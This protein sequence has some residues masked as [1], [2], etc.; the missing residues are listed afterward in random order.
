M[1]QAER[2]AK[3]RYLLDEGRWPTRPFLLDTLRVSPATLKR[4]RMNEPVVFDRERRGWRLDP[5][6]QLAGTQYELPG[7]WLSAEEIHALLTMQH[8]LAHLD[9]GGLL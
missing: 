1:S 6:A 2:L 4:D 8:V 7:L 9:T 3:L 5:A